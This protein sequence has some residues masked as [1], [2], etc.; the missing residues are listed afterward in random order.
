MPS[1]RQLATPDFNFGALGLMEK[2]NPQADKKG[3]F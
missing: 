2:R 1:S 3:Q